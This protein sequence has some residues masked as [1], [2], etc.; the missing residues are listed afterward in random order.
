[1]QR[2]FANVT[3]GDI[4]AQDYHAA[5][6]LERHG[7]DFC[8]GGRI[9]LADACR[10]RGLAVEPIAVELGQLA[11]TS[12]DDAPRDPDELMTHIVQRHHA[13]VRDA[14]PTIQARFAKVV[15]AHGDRHAE[16]HRMSVCFDILSD[17]L[18][19]HLAKE[20]QVLFPYIRSLAA[21]SRSGGAPPPDVFGTVQNPIRM[22]EV[23]HQSAGDE[24]A[25]IRSL[26]S[27]YQTPDGACATFRL[28]YT[29]LEAFER[30]LHRHVHLENNVLFPRAIELEA[31][32]GRKGRIGCE[33]STAD[34]RCSDDD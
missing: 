9:S 18:M 25:E 12:P 29:E 34:V 23:E 6:I 19:P 28:L 30:D 4:V 24:L 14:I 5:A 22:M 2:Q 7:L 26:A 21:A 17:E 20:E 33:T 3:L 11:A 32:V 31:Q 8:C 27:G 16:L 10:E 15:A 13:F 1:M